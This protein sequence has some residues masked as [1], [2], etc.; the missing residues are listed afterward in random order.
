MEIHVPKLIASIND[1]LSN[2]HSPQRIL[3]TE[4]ACEGIIRVN[5]EGK[6]L[7]YSEAENSISSSWSSI[8]QTEMA[9]IDIIRN[10]TK[11]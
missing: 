11:I 6:K 5:I 10:K 7:Q 3:N 8:L 9:H 1:K 2:Y 4:M